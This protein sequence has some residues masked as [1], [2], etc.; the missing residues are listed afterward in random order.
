MGFL[1]GSDSGVSAWNAGDLALIPGLVRSSGE[2]NGNPL[3]RGQQ[4]QHLQWEFRL[5]IRLY[6]SEID[7]T[8]KKK[9]KTTA[10]IYV[11]CSA[12]NILELAA[13][14]DLSPNNTRAEACMILLVFLSWIQDDCCSFYC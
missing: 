13:S 9:K 2:G 11:N 6:P 8:G 3:A 10:S 1:S 7:L 4:Y 5:E 14:T 12:L